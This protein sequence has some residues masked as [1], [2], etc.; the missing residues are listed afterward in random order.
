[1]ARSL[2]DMFVYA[3]TTKPLHYVE[4][5]N[6][7]KTAAEKIARPQD[8]RQVQYNE[9][10]KRFKVYSGSY[11]PENDQML[12]KK[13]WCIATATEPM[14][15][16]YQRKSTNQTVRYD[17]G[18]HNKNGTWIDGHYHWYIWWKNGFDTQESKRI[19]RKQNRRKRTEKVYYNKYGAFTSFSN[20]DHH[21]QPHK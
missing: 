6:P 16:F 19:R 12:L 3:I 14:N 1:M 15:H 17:V 7:P 13:G 2:I 5:K 10:S 20:P 9:W 8:A 21:I 4:V 18:H 11:L